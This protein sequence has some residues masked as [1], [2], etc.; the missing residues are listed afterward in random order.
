KLLAEFLD[1]AAGYLHDR[2]RPVIFWGEFPLKPADV[3]SLP[4]W[5]V[6]GE[7]NDRPFNTAFKAR[8]IRQTI[9]VSTQGEE[10]LFPDYY[11]L[12]ASEKLHTGRA[13]QPRVQD[14]FGKIANDPAR[15]D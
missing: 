11:I 13:G 2:G 15:R 1:K 10:R 5:L 7:V 9:Y 3:P 6:N 4:P 12:P 14:A 8:G